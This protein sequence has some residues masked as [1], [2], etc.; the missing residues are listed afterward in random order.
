[1]RIATQL[2]GLF[3]LVVALVACGQVD[4]VPALRTTD[5]NV[6]AGRYVIVLKSNAKIDSVVAAIADAGG[7]VVRA[8]P[9]AGILV[10]TALDDSFAATM[11][12][13]RA[14]QAAG[15]VPAEALPDVR[16]VAVLE[17]GPTVADDLYSAGLVWGVQRVHAPE[18]WDN[19]VTGSNGTV[20]AIIDTGIA[21]NHPDLSPNLVYNNCFVGAGSMEDGVCIAYPSLSYH[22]TH[23]AGTVAAAFGGG[24]VVGVGPNLGLANY[25]TFEVIPGCG[26]CSYSDS[27]WAAMVDAAESGFD[28]INMSLG[29]PLDLGIGKGTNDLTA[30]LQ[31]ER[32]IAAY[33]ES[34]GTVMVASAG[35][36]ATDL[37]GV[38]TH[39]PGDIPAIVNVSA[40]GIWPEPV[41]S[42]TSVDV[43]AFYSN[44]GAPV[45]VAAPGGDCGPDFDCDNDFDHFVLS[46]YVDA[47]SG[48]AATESCTV[49]YAYVAGTS[50]AAPHV[51]GVVGLI[52]SVKD[53]LNPNQIKSVLRRSAD[54]AGDRLL[55]GHGIVNAYEATR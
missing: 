55:F 8:L 27:R 35:N 7:T 31:A 52:Q 10:A 32:K 39:V 40:T 29:G 4:E 18:A 43:L 38:A 9:Q 22:G 5:A 41:Y 13:N 33:V 50:M 51:S 2:V 45:T 36:A 54:P 19:G 15:V 6:D 30:Y 24:R 42:D 20:V 16:D 23:V 26:V 14:V 11:N 17:D 3:A 21:S 34:Y 1:M 25:N 49:G 12:A 46:T 48:C 28:V 47:N 44:Y 37:N 53:N